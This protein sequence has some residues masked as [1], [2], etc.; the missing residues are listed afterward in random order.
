MQCI[1]LS[2][3]LCSQLERQQLVCVVQWSM[4]LVL[5]KPDLA[6]AP[7]STTRN[8]VSI[9]TARC[10]TGRPHLW[11][12]V[13]SGKGPRGPGDLPCRRF[14]QS[15]PSELHGMAVHVCVGFRGQPGHNPAFPSARQSVLITQSQQKLIQQG[16]ATNPPPPLKGGQRVGEHKRQDKEWR[17]Y[18]KLPHARL[19]LSVNN[20]ME[21]KK[22]TAVKS[23]E[24]PAR[25]KQ[26]VN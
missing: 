3:L 22:E 6:A 21:R 20:M 26:M 9:A 12:T 1:G 17:V 15:F 5:S 8:C 11:A 13:S 16:L 4:S 2:F 23:F 14:A 18:Y 19:S 25:S 7:S 10:F 24:M